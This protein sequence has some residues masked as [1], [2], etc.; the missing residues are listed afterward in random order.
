MGI[1]DLKSRLGTELEPVAYE[2]EKGMVQRFV[3]AIGDPNPRWQVIVPPTF[4][5]TINLEQ[6]QQLL[7]SN[8]SETL[9]H[10]ST[11]LECYRPVGLGDVL[12][13]IAK[14]TNVRERQGKM[15]KT[16]FI[17][18]DTTYKNQRQEL[19]A[20]CRQMVISY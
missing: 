1:D 19:V 5:L 3:Q 4:V 10:G 15:G 8:S 7:A 2:I 17:T 11:E 16:A 18:V 20:K 12:T 9:L 14:I 13:A 6:I